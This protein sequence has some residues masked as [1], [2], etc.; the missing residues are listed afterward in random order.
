MSFRSSFGFLGQVTFCSTT[1]VALFATGFAF[2]V[3]VFTTAKFL[4]VTLQ[5]AF[6]T[7]SGSSTIVSQYSY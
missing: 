5:Y 1:F 6:S 2:S 4:H 3:V 7:S